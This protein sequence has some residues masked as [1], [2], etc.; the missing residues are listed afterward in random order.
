MSAPVAE[1]TATISVRAPT[2]QVAGWLERALAPEATREVPRAKAQLGR[3]QPTVVEIVIQARDTGSLRA[4]LNT[5][6]GWV[7]LSLATLP[8]AER[9]TSQ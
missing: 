2:E 4:A 6:L 7:H 9:G 1:W 8:K 5:Y 3:P